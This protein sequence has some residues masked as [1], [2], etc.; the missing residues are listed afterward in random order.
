VDV[1]FRAPVVETE[2]APQKKSAFRFWQSPQRRKPLLTPARTRAGEGA[3]NGRGAPGPAVPWQTI[4][5]GC[6]AVEKAYR[7]LVCPAC[8]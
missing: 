7:P 1:N 6:D 5:Q 4:G 3:A 2:R 8:G